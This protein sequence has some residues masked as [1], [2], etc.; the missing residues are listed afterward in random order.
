MENPKPK[1]KMHPAL[2]VVLWVVGIFI[3]TGII[4]V[5]TD[6]GDD[7]KNENPVTSTPESKPAAVPQN[8]ND[9]G[10]WV[11]VLQ[12]KENGSKKSA[13]FHLSGKVPVLNMIIKVAG[14]IWALCFIYVLDKSVDYDPAGRLVTDLMI[15]AP[16]ENMKPLFKKQRG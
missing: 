7:K 12:L 5:A 4:A 13:P 3:V 11:E 14:M 10:E 8:N 9:E 2:K 1:K 15:D 6:S 16:E